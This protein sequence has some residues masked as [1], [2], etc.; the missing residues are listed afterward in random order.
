M[1]QAQ[2]LADNLLKLIQDHI[3]GFNESIPKHQRDIYNK[4]AEL[5]KGLQLKNGRIDINNIENYK[6]IPK[7]LKEIESFMLDPAYQK[8]VADYL[9]AFDAVSAVHNTYFSSLVSNFKP[10]KVLAE[11]R[12]QSIDATLNSLTEAG[13]N[14]YIGKKAGELLRT[15]ITSGMKYADMVDSLR[16]FIVGDAQADGSL[17]RYAK[18]I[19]TDALNQ[20]SAQYSSTLSQDL[21]LEWGMY[22]GSNI[23]TTRPFCE[24]LTKKRYIHKSELST[25]LNVSIDGVK[26]CSKEIP[27]AK[28]TG[29]PSGMIP[30]TNPENF[31][32][33]R[34][35]YN[36]GHQFIWV[37]ESMVP[38]DIVERV[39]KGTPPP[40]Q[41]PTPQ[42]TPP[43]A[44]KKPTKVSVSE[45]KTLTQYQEKLSKDY[46]V[47]TEGINKMNPDIV[48]PIMDQFMSL[49]DQYNVNIKKI[50]VNTIGK[51]T[52]AQALTNKHTLEKEITFNTNYFGKAIEDA[53]PTTSE[54]QTKW[55]A[56]FDKGNELKYTVTHE[57]GHVIATIKSLRSLGKQS[58]FTEEFVDLYFE[59]AK[60]IRPLMLKVNKEYRNGG[61]TRDSWNALL[62]ASVSRYANTSIEEFLA[63]S[64]ANVQLSSNPHPYAVRAVELIDKYFKK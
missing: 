13:V 48:G 44:P 61:I 42:P 5:L 58:K 45:P 28:T 21:G 51:R 2:K 36:C 53:S 37:T 22:V 56:T 14:E 24:H 33:N 41:K 26:L 4:V 12:K 34:G 30:G 50:S 16:S 39:K 64:F 7:V 32:I 10:T 9:T 55:K 54:V 29:L 15:S 3:D 31:I 38:K 59:Y 62:E 63:E 49:A 40:V 57:F 52:K 23:V 47:T 35:G 1:P 18:Q 46:N 19:T 11:V 60:K 17:A 6:L 25:V 43:T 20:Y 27:C 8:S